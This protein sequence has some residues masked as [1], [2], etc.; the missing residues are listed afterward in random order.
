LIFVQDKKVTNSLE[1]DTGE[2][3]GKKK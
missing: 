2:L 1:M 3:D